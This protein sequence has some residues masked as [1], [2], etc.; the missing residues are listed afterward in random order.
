MCHRSCQRW[1][2]GWQ[3]GGGYQAPGTAVPGN[4]C[5]ARIVWAVAWVHRAS[6]AQPCQRRI[7]RPQLRQGVELFLAGR[8]IG[9]RNPEWDRVWL[10]LLT[11]HQAQ[12][13]TL[14]SAT[15]VTPACNCTHFL[16]LLRPA[17]R[18][19]ESLHVGPLAECHR[20]SQL[21]LSASPAACH[22]SA[23]APAAWRLGEARA[24]IQPS[25]LA[26]PRLTSAP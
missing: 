10:H 17:A 5:G 23:A 14:F 6:R 16:H 24:S 26:S 19:A 7:S 21:G 18:P 3:P 12:A 2:W 4:D 15:G 11:P 20:A 1:G 8:T 22:S 13:N 25:F 9:A